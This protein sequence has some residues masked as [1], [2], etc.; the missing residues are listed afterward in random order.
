M[1]DAI[2]RLGSRLPGPWRAFA[3]LST[4]LILLWT[5]TWWLGP[6]VNL[7]L[8]YDRIGVL[9]GEG[10][11]LLT[12]H[13]V[14]CS[15]RH[16]L[17]NIA[18]LGLVLELVG[19]E[20]AGREWLLVTAASVVAIDAG[21]L[22]LRP[23]LQWYVGLSGVLH[24]MLAAGALA[25]WRS[26][27]PLFAAALSAIVVAKL[28]R[29]QIWGALP[30]AGDLPVVVDAHLFGAVGGLCAAAVIIARRGSLRRA[31]RGVRS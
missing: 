4:I 3:T 2:R 29:E 17:L 12:G 13:L 7:S 26:E 27:R 9:R 14:H 1:S 19:R 10:W 28:L 23:E 5:L 16:L 21:F 20:F 18:G 15:G 30:L 31:A 24:G 11:R 8:R 25:W 6:A 22:L